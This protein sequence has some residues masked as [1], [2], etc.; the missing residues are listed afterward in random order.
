MTKE[1]V[2]I[3]VLNDLTRVGDLYLSGI[4]VMLQYF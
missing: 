2:M 1:E 4:N 3:L